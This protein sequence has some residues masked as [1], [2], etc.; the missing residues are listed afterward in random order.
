[1]AW[2]QRE[3]R[4]WQEEGVVD[5]LLAERIAG[6]YA[7]GRGMALGRLALGL[8]ATFVGIGLIWLVATNLDQL[9]PLTRIVGVTAV[10]LSAVVIAEVLA[11]RSALATAAARLI[12]ALAAGAVVFQAA[13]SLQV[14][15]YTPSLLGVWAAG[16]LAYTYATSGVGPLIVAIVTGTGWYAWYVGERTGDPALIA[17]SLVLAAAVGTAIAALHES[18]W[19]RPFAR[20]W[21]QVGALLALVGLFLVALPSTDRPQSIP[22]L[23]WVGIAAAGLIGGLAL[24]LGD[25]QGRHEVL[26]I[27]AVTAA[28]LSLLAWSPVDPGQSGLTAMQLIHAVVATAVYVLTAAWFAAVSALHDDPH[29]MTLSTGALVV[30]V[31]VQS[32]AIFAPLLSGAA[33]FLVLGVV[34]LATGGLVIRGRR[35]LMAPTSEV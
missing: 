31:T 28:T 23:L 5:A 3:L 19:R 26:A 33:L 18:R 32:F 25:R 8:G 14:P 9:S 24:A 6:R 1:M 27:G 35:R 21:R 15:A 10:W 22:L 2:L 12:A 29:L 7:A 13:Q 17:A 30:F 34:F 4:Q 16:V 11:H 20:P